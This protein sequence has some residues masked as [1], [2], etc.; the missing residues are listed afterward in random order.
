MSTPSTGTLRVRHLVRGTHAVERSAQ[1]TTRLLR[2]IASWGQWTE[3]EVTIGAAKARRSDAVFTIKGAVP[4]SWVEDLRWALE[5]AAELQRCSTP[6]VPTPGYVAELRP[7]RDF[8][9]LPA[10]H[11]TEDGRGRDLVAVEIARQR[12]LRERTPWPEP[13]FADLADLL[14]FNVGSAKPRL[15]LVLRYRLGAAASV[16]EDMAGQAVRALWDPSRGDVDDYVGTP[17]RLRALIGSSLGPLPARVE[18]VVRQ[19]ASFLDLVPLDER[20]SV[21][22]WSGEPLDLAG[23][24]VPRG[25]A[26]AC[27]RLPTAGRQPF[28]GMRT[29]EPPVP[30][31]PLDPVPATPV[32]GIRL[33]RATTADGSRTDVLLSP[34][35]LRQHMFIQGASGSGK[36]TLE[37]ALATGLLDAGCSFTFLDGGEGAI[38]MILDR[39]PAEHAHKVRV[40]R[41]GVSS[42]NAPVNLLAAPPDKLERMVGLFAE[43]TQQ[44]LDP[45]Q[46][47]FVGPR[48]RRY[49]TLIALNLVAALGNDAN[50]VSVA[51]ISGN[52]RLVQH[53]A[54][55]T[56]EIAPELSSQ[57]ESEYANLPRNEA[58]ELASWG[59]SKF[60]E[61]LSSE[62]I[63]WVL[64]CGPDAL[65]ITGAMDRGESLLIDLGS[66]DLG[67]TASRAIGAAY[68]LKHWAALGE[69]DNR[70]H[71]HVIIVDETHLFSYGPLPRLLAEARKFG[72]AVVVATQHL[73]QLPDG[74]ADAVESNTGTFISLRSGLQSAQRASTRLMGWP[75]QDL[76]RLPNLT[77]AAT[78]TRDGL[79]TAPFSLAIDFHE[80][81][82]R[83][84][85]LGR[86][87]Q[88][89]AEGIT[90]RS[91]QDLAA[92]SQLSPISVVDLPRRLDAVRPK[93]PEE[94]QSAVDAWLAKRKEERHEPVGEQYE[95]PAVAEE[96]AT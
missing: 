18:A 25:F 68:L 22:A 19:W 49:F 78:M 53:L 54:R 73:G 4:P 50:I 3:L 91:R 93:P 67:Q 89:V 47:G 77:G 2:V 8:S 14:G 58:T 7:S 57:L 61:L 72:I 87:G 16:E 74:L 21:K 10:M 9:P 5:G 11:D 83:A 81:S 40:V 24:A 30:V 79:V 70:D 66:H 44:A 32:P 88:H 52:P 96:V 64:G 35:D 29:A 60:Q 15:D 62:A 42:L 71:T 34:V 26:I 65:D 27:V 13:K 51:H 55:A 37:A 36:T 46:E 92:Y 48:W 76:V 31:I 6:E 20:E 56:R 86:I 12:D 17:V 41:H 69:R 75:A 94:K 23:H 45:K 63:R 84:R 33:G 28:P 59:A 39:I 1:A 95:I 38:D 82:R 90:A 85:R 80:R 43:M